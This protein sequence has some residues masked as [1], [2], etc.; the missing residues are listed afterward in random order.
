MNILAPLP[1]DVW[2]DFASAITKSKCECNFRAHF[3]LPSSVTSHLWS[4]ILSCIGLQPFWGAQELLQCL[5]FLKSPAS[6]WET[7]ASRFGCTEKTFVK[8]LKHSLKIID[9]S[10]PEVFNS[11]LLEKKIDFFLV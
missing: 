4:R 9:D 2:L 11:I 1:S 8:H 3:G 6:S 7:N 5:H 10:L